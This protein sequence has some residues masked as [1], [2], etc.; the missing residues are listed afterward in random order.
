MNERFSFFL[1]LAL[2][3]NCRIRGGGNHQHE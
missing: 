2:V 3:V 1:G